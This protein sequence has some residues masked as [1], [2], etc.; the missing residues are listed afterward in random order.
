MT[1]E[2]YLLF[3]APL[4]LLAFGSAMYAFLTHAEGRRRLELR[5]AKSRASV[6]R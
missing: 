6:K 3:V 5:P 1:A 2:T 4:M